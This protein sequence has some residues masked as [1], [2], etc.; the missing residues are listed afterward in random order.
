MLQVIAGEEPGDPTAAKQP[1]EDFG[2]DM[3]LGVQGMRIGI[4]PDVLFQADQPDVVKGVKEALERFRSLGAEVVECKVEHL[5]LMPKA[6][7]AVC[8]TEASAFHQKNMRERPQDYGEDVRVLFQ[9]GEFLPG[10]AYVHAQ[11]YRRWL[12]EQ[13]ETLFREKIDLLLFPTLPF[14]AVPIGEYELEINGKVENVLPLS[15]TYVCYAPA[16]GLPAVTIPCGLDHAGLPIGIQLLGGA[17][18]EHVC[19]RAAAS[20]EKVFHLYDRLPGLQ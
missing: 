4:L 15:G 8:Y 5:D 1:S 7:S 2:R 10:T 16:T 14:T 13:F 11:R 3:E 12:R 17:F 19:Y 6:W 18:C 20:F 9:A